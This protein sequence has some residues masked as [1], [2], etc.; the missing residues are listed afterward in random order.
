MIPQI[1]SGGSFA[2]PL[3]DAKIA[4]YEALVAAVSTSPIRDA[5]LRLLALLKQWWELP[6]STGTPTRPHASGTGT[7][8]ML[9]GA[10]QSALFDAI[11][12]REELTLF[13]QLFESI[14]NGTQK[15]HRDAA[16]HLLW[17]AFELE[18]D[19]EPL[20]SDKL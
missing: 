7:I 14:D 19:R 15:P 11:P 10:Y 8:V 9:D 13:G 5:L 1:H 2:P 4:E 3:T 16:H 6:E 12:W 20:T 18:L 17:H